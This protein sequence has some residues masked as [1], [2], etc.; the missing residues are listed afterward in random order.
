MSTMRAVVFLGKEQLEIATL[1]RPE[2][3]P[4][5]VLL[6]VAACGVCGGDA[7]S[8]FSGD[9]F[10]GL[11]RIP[12]HEVT[13]TVEAAGA[14]VTSWKPGDRLALAADVHCGDCWYC[15]R[16]LFN[17]CANL[18]ILGKHMD[19]GMAEYMLLT[20]EILE[21]GIVNRVPGDLG[22]LSAAL[23]EPLCSVLASHDELGIA[24]GETVAVIGCGPMGLLHYELLCARGAEAI[25]IDTAPARLDLA[26]AF[27]A[28]HV[29]QAGAEDAVSLV[30][31]LT[32]GAGADVV[33]TAAPSAQAVTSAL[34]TA[35]K[36]GRIGLFGGLPAAEANVAIDLNAVH[37]GEQR[38]I[39]NFSYHPRYHQRALETILSGGVRAQRLITCYALEDAARALADIRAGNVLKAVIVPEM[40]PSRGDKLREAG[41][42]PRKRSH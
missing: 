14:E 1:P 28:R 36:R 30:R 20:P 2:C 34:A 22:L 39:G 41:E 19:G 13:G 9:K 8:Y 42:R 3:G 29:I 10:T 40:S 31:E 38:I 33:I 4:H 17:L 35:R 18:K 25:M 37:Y 23:S 32:G 26:R 15:R 16:E 12:G 27:G 24:A 7:R 6:R 11:R 21:R 5:D